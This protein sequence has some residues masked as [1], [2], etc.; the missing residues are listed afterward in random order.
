MRKLTQ[1]QHDRK[2]EASR[3][4]TS[5]LLLVEGELHVIEGT[6]NLHVVVVGIGDLLL[7]GS[8]V[9]Y[10]GRSGKTINGKIKQV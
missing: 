8:N 9:D 3:L 2:G 4:G 7:L 6:G 5:K 10:S 1:T